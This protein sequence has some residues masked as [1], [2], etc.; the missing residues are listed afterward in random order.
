MAG[1]DNAYLDARIEQIKADILA[2]DAEISAAIVRPQSY[3]IE[4]AQTREQVSRASVRQLRE[5]RAALENE[6]AT[7]TA[8]RY[9]ASRYAR[10]GF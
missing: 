6:L 3:T 8:R 7:L 1:M 9:G 4:T 10:P 5:S 2:L